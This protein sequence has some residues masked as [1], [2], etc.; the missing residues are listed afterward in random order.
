[1]ELVV[2][3][4]YLLLIIISVINFKTRSL[5][6]PWMAWAVKAVWDHRD[7]TG[8]ELPKGFS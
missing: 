4:N 3:A 2:N 7:L 6:L 5:R 8:P 1:M